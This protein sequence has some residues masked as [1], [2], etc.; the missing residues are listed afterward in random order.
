MATDTTQPKKRVLVLMSDTG[1]G[2]RASAIALNDAFDQLYPGQLDTRIVDVF[3]E[4]CTA[5]PYSQ[6]VDIYKKLANE[7]L[8][9][10]I[11]WYGSA[12]P[13]FKV[14]SDLFQVTVVPTHIISCSV[15]GHQ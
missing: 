6:F 14:I 8:L 5:W 13:P 4:H 11:I 1:G 3:T 15:Q 7:P 10:A 2:H 9:W 12:I